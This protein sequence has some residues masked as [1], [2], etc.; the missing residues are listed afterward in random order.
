VRAGLQVKR[1]NLNRA[2]KAERECAERLSATKPTTPGGAAALIQ[3]VLD[4]DI[5]EEVEW[6]MTS[7]DTAV[8]A[9]NSMGAAVQS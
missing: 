4:D 5:C 2:F 6:H 8:A 9:L 1:E 7:L 3:H